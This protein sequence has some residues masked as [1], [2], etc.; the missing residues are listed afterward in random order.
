MPLA[1]EQVS[2]DGRRR[3]DTGLPAL[4]GTRRAEV[5]EALR[6]PQ[7]TLTLATALHLAPSTASE[8]L[9]ALARTGL[10]ARKRHGRRV[11]Y[12]L[13]DRGRELLFL[14]D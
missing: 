3:I 6:E 13:N 12:S 7:T 2:D 8:H 14:F 5:L 11:F 4:V 9:T 1:A 10:L